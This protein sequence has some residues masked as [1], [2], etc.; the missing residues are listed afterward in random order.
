[1]M[2]G[3][4]PILILKEGTTREKGHGAHH[5]NIAAAKAI[6]GVV[7]RSELHEDYILP[8]LFNEA[9]VPAVAAAVADEGYK[10]RVARRRS[11]RAT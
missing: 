5:N 4:T 8:S 6:A 10:A 3:Q 1:M 7:K 2:G 9:V 11:R